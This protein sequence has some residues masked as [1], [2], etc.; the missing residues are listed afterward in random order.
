M[1]TVGRSKGHNTPDTV[2][3]WKDLKILEWVEL[4]KEVETR[5]EGRVE[6]PC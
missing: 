6:E 5:N 2:L 3:V 4:G 1:S